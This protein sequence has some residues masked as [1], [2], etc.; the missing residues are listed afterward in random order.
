MTINPDAGQRQILAAIESERAQLM[1][2]SRPDAMKRLAER[3][4]M[5]PRAR[6][7]KLVDPGTFD[8]IGALASEEPQA[9][10]PHPRPSRLQVNRMPRRQHVRP[11]AAHPA[12]GHGLCAAE[13]TRRT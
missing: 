9:G 13:V 7:A 2:E 1:D 4:R 12:D 5:S 3:G 10:Q 8:E 11:A 6:I